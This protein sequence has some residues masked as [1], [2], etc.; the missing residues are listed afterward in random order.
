MGWESDLLLG[1]YYEKK[2]IELR[3]FKNVEHPLN[4]KCKEFDFINLNTG[5]SYEIKADRMA[6]KT[7]NIFIEYLCNGEKSGIDATDANYWIHFVCEKDFMKCTHYYKFDTNTLKK[8]INDKQYY[9]TVSCVGD[10]GRVSGYLFDKDELQ[11]YRFEC[12]I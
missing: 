3:N 1:Q 6:C 5:T 7:G 8:L 2:Y 4:T 9:R 10:G 11:D 12:N